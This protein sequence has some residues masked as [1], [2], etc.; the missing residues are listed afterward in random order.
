MAANK[1]DWEDVA[2]DDWEDLTTP[3]EERT[4]GGFGKNVITSGVK[5][6]ENLYGAATSPVQTV[7]NIANI[8]RGLGYLISEQLGSA[9][10][11]EEKFY[12]DKVKDLG[13]FFAERFG[14]WE[15]IKKTAYEDPVGF[16]A[17]LSTIFSGG[18]AALKTAGLT[19]YGEAASQLG[20]YTNPMAWP[21]GVSKAARGALKKVNTPEWI[22]ES[23][24]KIPPGSLRQELR[25][26]VIQTLLKE[27]LPLGKYT[28]DKINSMVKD[29]E[30]KI[31]GTLKELSDQGAEINIEVVSDALNK[32]K[33]KY[34]NRPDASNYLNAIE[35]AKNLFKEHSFVDKLRPGEG[36]QFA[37]GLEGGPGTMSLSK[38]QELKK[39]AY[40]NLESYF[41]KGAMPETGR[42]GIQNMPEADAVANAAKALRNSVLEHPSVPGEVKTALQREAG[43][44]TARKWVERAA[45]R[46][47]NIDPAGLSDMAFGILVE[48]GLP[49]AMAF[50]VARSQAMLSRLALWIEHGS[51]IAEKTGKVLRPTGLGLSQAGK[52]T[53]LTPRMEE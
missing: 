41:K 22:L 2:I 30:E 20:K 5:F 39:G 19:K 51:G 25:Q 1:D 17:D 35:D 3:K 21:G 45:N 13:N 23:T 14:G 34:I 15:N 36:L 52:Y 10:D 46:G 40:A 26:S 24:M 47:G 18:G 33:G 37:E 8:P 9:L 12:A 11:P 50:K 49:A 7:K 6:G 32:L 42:I 43:L 53:G 28:R 44:M 31:S 29:L 48:G 16:A 38:A 4:L 27:K